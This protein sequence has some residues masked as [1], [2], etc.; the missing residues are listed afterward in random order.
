MDQ[1]VEQ[2]AERCC[3]HCAAIRR[4]YGHLRRAWAAGALLPRARLEECRLNHLL[5]ARRPQSVEPLLVGEELQ[6]QRDPDVGKVQGRYREGTG[7][8]SPTCSSSGIRM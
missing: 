6:Q 8:V 4:A 2:K 3:E 1:L 7:K 5:Y